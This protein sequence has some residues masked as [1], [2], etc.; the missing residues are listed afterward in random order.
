MSI[1]NSDLFDIPE[2]VKRKLIEFSLSIDLEKVS[3]KGANGYTFFGMNRVLNREVAVKFYYWGSDPKHHA[4]PRNLSAIR[5]DHVVPILDAAFV[6]EDYAYFMMPY[7]PNGDMDDLIGKGGV[8]G[9]KHAVQLTQDILTG[10]V[11]LHSLRLLHR[12]LK[13]QNILIGERGQA[14]IGDFG[15][16]KVLP[17]GQETIPGSGHSLIYR[18]P[19]SIRFN[20][21]GITGDLYQV[22]ILL[23]QLLG[24]YLPYN[25]VDWLN[26]REMNE[27]SALISDADRSIFANRVISTKIEQGRVIN[28]CTL[29][30]WVC[31]SLRRTVKRACHIV[32][33][34]RFESTAA[35]L[36]HIAKLASD[37][38]DWRVVDG[39]PTLLGKVNYRI[40]DSKQNSLYYVEKRIK[41][42]WR[43]DNAFVY[44][45][46]DELVRII[47]EIGDI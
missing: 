4:E 35:F 45:K 19:E 22:G 37:I 40:C 42:G 33:S 24:G 39:C 16:V 32:P 2:P 3:D 30:P 1:P 7:F 14:L 46:I 36:A 15:S 10:L 41:S 8:S 31:G 11:E 29:P 44:S 17:E 27:Y 43:R 20:H 6:D 21:Y 18:P 13:P 28:I 12:D 5:S 9:I 23:F 25:E 34:Q 26:K 47:E 38:H